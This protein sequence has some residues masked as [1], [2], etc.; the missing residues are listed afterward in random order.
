VYENSEGEIEIINYVLSVSLDPYVSNLRVE[1][2]S[3]ITV[4]KFQ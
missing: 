2:I 1:K 3:K 4:N